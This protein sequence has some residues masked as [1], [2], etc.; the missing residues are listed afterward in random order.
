M[1]MKAL[2]NFDCGNQK[3]Q[4]GKFAV[5][6]SACNRI[7]DHHFYQPGLVFKYSNSY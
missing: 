4:A 1:T 6:L 3:T 7:S 5:L 2:L